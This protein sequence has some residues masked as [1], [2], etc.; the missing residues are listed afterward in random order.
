MPTDPKPLIV[1]GHLIVRAD[2]TMRVT[3][4]KRLA[5]DEVAFPV[6]VSIPRTWGQVQATRIEVALPNPPEARVTVGPP[7]LDPDPDPEPSSEYSGDGSP[8]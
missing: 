3:K 7:E 4:G 6:T 8:A 5:L 2:G 1:S